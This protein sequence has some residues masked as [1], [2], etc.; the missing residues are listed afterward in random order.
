MECKLYS[1]ANFFQQ[2]FPVFRIALQYLWRTASKGKKWK[3]NKWKISGNTWK[4]EIINDVIIETYLRTKSIQT[5]NFGIAVLFVEFYLLINII[6][7]SKSARKK[8]QYIIKCFRLQYANSLLVCSIK[9][10]F[11]NCPFIWTGLEIFQRVSYNSRMH[12]PQENKKVVLTTAAY[13][14]VSTPSEAIM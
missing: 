1:V 5:K 7:V 8:T 11:K 14:N 3:F 10:K 2:I 12:S 9:K 6:L 13:F 4:M